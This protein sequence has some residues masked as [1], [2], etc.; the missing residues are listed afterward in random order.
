M[1]YLIFLLASGAALAAIA[2]TG[3]KINSSASAAAGALQPSN[4]ER[5]V[6]QAS[7]DDKT[8]LVEKTE[9]EGPLSHVSVASDCDEMLPGLS[10]LHYWSESSDGT[11]TLSAD[12]RTPAVVFAQA[13]G[14]AYE[15]IEPRMPIMALMESD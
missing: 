4:I 9:G 3:L 11:V 10:G 12:G 14:V 2:I 6:M 7:G 13:D 1:R 15:S 5:F 8:C